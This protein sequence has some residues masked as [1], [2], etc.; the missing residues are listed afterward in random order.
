MSGRVPSFPN[1]G[2]MLSKPNR[3]DQDLLEQQTRRGRVDEA[4]SFWPR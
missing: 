1:G 3:P 4:L 2:Q